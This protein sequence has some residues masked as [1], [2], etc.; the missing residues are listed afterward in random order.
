[1]DSSFKYFYLPIKINIKSFVQLKMNIMSNTDLIF[2]QKITNTQKKSISKYSRY[3]CD[4]RNL[5]TNL[6][7]A[8]DFDDTETNVSS[9]RSKIELLVECYANTGIVLEQFNAVLKSCPEK[10]IDSETEPDFDNVLSDSKIVR[11]YKNTDEWRDLNKRIKAL[12]TNVN[13]QKN[14]L[15]KI[16]NDMPKENGQGKENPLASQT[17]A[18]IANDCKVNI[19]NM[20]NDIDSLLQDYQFKFRLSSFEHT[21]SHPLL[22]SINK[23]V[24]YLKQT[25]RELVKLDK[26]VTP[27]PTRVTSNQLVTQ[28]EDLVA[29]MLLIVQSV[30]KKH[31]PPDTTENAEVINAIDEIIKSDK[32]ESKDIVE[33]KHLKEH[34][35]DKLSNDTRMLQLESLITKTQLLYSNYVEHLAINNVDEEVRM[36]VMRVVPILEQTVL[37]VQ[38][39]VTQKVSVHRVSC[40]MLSVLLKI[41][42]DL[43][44]KG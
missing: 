13:K 20:I 2:F 39:F 15:H 37:F 26:R 31:L 42:S 6:I 1:M 28:T 41:F 44:S 23:L 27:K 38:Y 17:H 24:S 8:L 16:S 22:K 3:L 32:E 4:L 36:A 11:C 12:I 34:L 7:D 35:Q 29:T 25:V 18:T 5:S 9:L 19:E 40:K 43:A 21:P 33:D 14:T 10:G 30:Y